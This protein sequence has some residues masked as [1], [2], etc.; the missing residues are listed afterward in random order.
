[1]DMSETV[2]IK[3]SVI[4]TASLVFP[5]STALNFTFG[6][7]ALTCGALSL[8]LPNVN[9]I[10]LFE[11]RQ[12]SEDTCLRALFWSTRTLCIDFRLRLSVFYVRSKGL[13][14]VFMK[15]ITLIL[16]GA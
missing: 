2:R 9:C 3:V 11:P 12:K 4:D 13:F 6:Y 5:L 7:T 8:V 14:G 16:H 15:S 1:M 10:L